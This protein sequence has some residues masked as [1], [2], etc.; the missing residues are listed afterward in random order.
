MGSLDKLFKSIFKESWIHTIIIALLKLQ[1]LYETELEW[2]ANN[3]QYILLWGVILGYP[4]F[5]PLLLKYL[6][7]NT[8]F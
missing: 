2:I 6:G 1:I 8:N 5:F 3:K 7:G 4:S